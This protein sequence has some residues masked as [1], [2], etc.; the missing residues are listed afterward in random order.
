MFSSTFVLHWIYTLIWSL[1]QS[2]YHHLSV[3][4]HYILQHHSLAVWQTFL[5]MFMLNSPHQKNLT[6][7]PEH[8]QATIQY[9]KIIQK[10]EQTLELPGWRKFPQAT[11]WYHVSLK[12]NILFKIKEGFWETI[13]F[14]SKICHG[15][16]AGWNKYKFYFTA[17]E[18]PGSATA[19]PMD[20]LTLG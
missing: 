9:S 20:Q 19:K 12:Q 18:L 17:A 1:L 11:I 16:E 8:T 10:D 6:V 2:S 14:W 5:S 15:M 3:C 7:L 13:C 4:Q